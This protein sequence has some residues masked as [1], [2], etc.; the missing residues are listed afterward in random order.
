METVYFIY[1]LLAL[2]AVIIIAQFWIFKNSK[3]DFED[4]FDGLDEEFKQNEQRMQK[5]DEDLKSVNDLLQTYNKIITEK[6]AELEHYKNASLDSKQKGLFSSLINIS[7]FIEKFN[8]DN[9]SLDEKTKNYLIAIQDKLEIA[10]S[11]SGIEKFEPNLNENIMEVIGC[12]PSKIT[13]KTKDSNKINLISSVIKPG[14]RILIRDDKFNYIKN[15]EVEI[16][17]LEK[18][19]AK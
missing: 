12:T 9:P 8:K 14:Y 5:M 17:E 6:T 18:K 15:A 19:W 2:S 4:L 10:L 1:F 7:D 16:F 3:K 11:S 13:K